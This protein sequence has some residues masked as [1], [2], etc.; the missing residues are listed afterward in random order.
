MSLL[1]KVSLDGGDRKLILSGILMAGLANIVPLIREFIAWTRY[2]DVPEKSIDF[3][4]LGKSFTYRS[5]LKAAMAKYPD[6][7]KKAVEVAVAEALGSAKE[8]GFSKWLFLGKWARMTSEQARGFWSALIVLGW[9]AI[10]PVPPMV[11]V[12]FAQ[13]KFAIPINDVVQYLGS[14]TIGVFSIVVLGKIVSAIENWYWQ[15]KVNKLHEDVNE[16][17]GPAYRSGEYSYRQNEIEA[18]MSG[19]DKFMMQRSIPLVR[20]GYNDVQELLRSGDKREVLSNETPDNTPSEGDKAMIARQI[21]DNIYS[22]D[23]AVQDWKPANRLTP[24][25]S[26][27]GRTVVNVQSSGEFIKTAFDDPAM[28]RLL[29]NAD[30]L[31][32]IIYNIRTMTPSMVDHFVG[33]DQ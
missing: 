3:K 16:V 20:Q 11:A 15:G 2:R 17:F 5:Y 6:N 22:T 32:P 27:L 19:I 24:G 14:A 8:S 30:G 31:A 33:V 29:L 9:F 13:Y 4:L 12:S 1:A 26:D 28:L 23:R 7:S 10:V 18:L 21:T 25:G